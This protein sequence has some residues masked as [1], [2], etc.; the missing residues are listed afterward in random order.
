MNFPVRNRSHDAGAVLILAIGF[1][2][3]IGAIGAALIGIVGSSVGSGRALDEVRVR[4]YAAEG[5]VEAAIGLVRSAPTDSKC[6]V[7]PYAGGYRSSIGASV[8]R[9]AGF[10]DVSDV[11]GGFVPSAQIVTDPAALYLAIGILGATVMPH[12]LYLHSSIVQ[13]RAYPRDEAGK[14]SALRFAVADSTIALTLA[15]F[16]NAAILIMAAKVFH[17]SGHTGVQEIEEAHALLSPLLGVGLASTLFALALLAPFWGAWMTI[18]FALVLPVLLVLGDLMASAPLEIDAPRAIGFYTVRSLIIGG[19]LLWWADHLGGT[20]T[21]EDLSLRDAGVMGVAQAI[22]L[23]PGV[24]R[25][26]ITITAGLWLGIISFILA[27]LG[28]VGAWVGGAL[29]ISFI[30]NGTKVVSQSDYSVMVT[31]CQFSGGTATA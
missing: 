9:A 29:T 27:S 21:T 26:G 12:N 6:Y 11:L 10:A 30:N 8:L 24:S 17:G 20:R 28:L 19:L 25:S 22:A 14:K 16:V 31:D 5:A 3:L 7:Q 4:Q 13:T 15:L 1:V 18:G 23:Q 2:V